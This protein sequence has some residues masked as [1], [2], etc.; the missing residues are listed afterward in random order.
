MISEE[1]WKKLRIWVENKEPKKPVDFYEH[2]WN[3]LKVWL[4][5]F[6]NPQGRFNDAHQD[7]R[8]VFRKMYDLETGKKNDV[9]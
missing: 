7:M 3:E 4:M 6:V 5:G 8:E 9:C 2:N 1:K